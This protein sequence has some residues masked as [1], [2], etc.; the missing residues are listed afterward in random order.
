MPRLGLLIR[1][2]KC[3][4]RLTGTET[5]QEAG[6]R[7]S[8][9]KVGD[10]PEITTLA[11]EYK[12][13]RAAETSLP[14]YNHSSRIRTIPRNIIRPSSTQPLTSISHLISNTSA[15]F[16]PHSK[17]LPKLPRRSPALV[18]RPQLE[19]RPLKRRRL[20]RR[21]RRHQATR[22]SGPRPERRLTHHT[23]TRVQSAHFFAS[24][25]VFP[26]RGISQLQAVT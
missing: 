25:R 2:G 23:S 26:D 21:R 20:E 24:I 8:T 22:R 16:A 6:G 9:P 1:K 13:A 15:L 18:A 19:R 12:F 10:S 7:Q 17:C 11:N 5:R 14:S 3:C 4:A